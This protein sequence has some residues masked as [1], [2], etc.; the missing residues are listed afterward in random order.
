VAG[1]ATLLILEKNPLL[2][3]IVPVPPPI[4]KIADA[5]SITL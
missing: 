3:D 4:D 2:T 1:V 5:L